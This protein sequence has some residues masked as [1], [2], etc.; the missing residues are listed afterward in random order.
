MPPDRPNAAAAHAVTLILSSRTAV[1][2]IKQKLAPRFH[3]FHGP[4]QKAFWFEDDRD[5]RGEDDGNG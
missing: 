4:E 2:T 1:T 3:P 5:A